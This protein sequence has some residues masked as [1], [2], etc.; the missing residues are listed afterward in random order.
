MARPKEFD[1]DNALSGAME[2][3]RQ[4]GYGATAIPDLLEAMKIS[5][6]SLYDTYGDKYTLYLS[7][8]DQ[9]YEYHL[10]PKLETLEAK[11]AS[12]DEIWDFFF[13][14]VEYHCSMIK[15]T[16]CFL[17]NA[18]LEMP[19]DN[20]DIREI[21]NDFN[22]RMV[23]ALSG[24]ITRSIKTGELRQIKAP[25]PIAKFLANLYW[26][27]VLNAKTGTSKMDLNQTVNVALSILK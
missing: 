6:Q 10:V 17:A 13:S 1:I 8:L 20:E 12:L 18:A 27:I 14:L 24:A 21:I 19:G 25:E 23:D 22:K 5:R 11:S 2:C 26:G 16:S 7:S 4:N 9:Y 15:R 3:F